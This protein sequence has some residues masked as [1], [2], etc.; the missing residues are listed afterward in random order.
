M[1]TFGFCCKIFKYSKR[2]VKWTPLLP[3]DSTTIKILPYLLYLFIHFCWGMLSSFFFS[4]LLSEICL[5]FSSWGGVQCCLFADI[6][7][8]QGAGIVNR[9][10]PHS[11]WS[12]WEK[13]AAP[14]WSGEEWTARLCPQPPRQPGWMRWGRSSAF[15]WHYRRKDLVKRALSS[16]AHTY[17]GE[18]TFRLCLKFWCLS[19]PAILFPLFRILLVSLCFV[20]M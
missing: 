14:H 9:A 2:I 17:I 7:S 20:C 18:L 19:L 16:K 1:I 11:P 12:S 6:H 13:K 10:P 8:V 4:S 3:S 15:L 5:P